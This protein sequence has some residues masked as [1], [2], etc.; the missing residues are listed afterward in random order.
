MRKA[1]LRGCSRG[2][3]NR[4]ARHDPRAV[5]APVRRNFF[6]T[7]PD[8]LWLADITH[9]RTEESILC[10]AFILDAHS[11][12]VVGLSMASH[13]RTELV[14][15]ALEMVLW[16]RKSAAGLVHHSDRGAQYTA[17]SLGR[18]LEAIK[19]CVLCKLP[20]GRLS[21]PRVFARAPR[22][23]SYEAASASSP[24]AYVLKRR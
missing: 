22:R 9:V 16:M 15:D 2:R 4:T 23:S 7:A 18:W 6:D 11:R 8:R 10:L 21:K 24:P 14:V 13:L 1:G 19:S 3:P 20:L 5:P 17:L 12:R